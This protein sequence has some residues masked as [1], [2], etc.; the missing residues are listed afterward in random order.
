[1]RSQTSRRNSRK[2][3]EQEKKP[4]KATKLK[5]QEEK[6]GKATMLVYQFLRN[7]M[8]LR[9]LSQNAKMRSMPAKLLTSLRMKQLVLTAAR[10]GAILLALSGR[11]SRTYPKSVQLKP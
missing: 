1:M 7:L 6:P 10:I 11:T 9:N 8:K 2:A 5:E 3:K 4:G